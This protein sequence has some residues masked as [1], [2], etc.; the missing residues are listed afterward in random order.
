MP[1]WNERQK[2]VLDSLEKDTSILVSA[3]AGSGK[4]A[5]LVQRII[6]TVK[7]KKAGIDEILVVTFTKAAASQMK[8]KIIKSLEAEAEKGENEEL[9]RQLVL[10]E[11]A[12]IM[13]ID[14]FCNKVVRNNFSIARMDPSF[15]IQD[16]D[17]ASILKEEVLDKVLDNHYKNDKVFQDIAGYIMEKNIK[18]DNL[19]KIILN[20]FNV[21]ESYAESDKWLE[22]AREK[23]AQDTEILEH[24]WVIDYIEYVKSMARGYKAVFERRAARFSL[25]QSE[26]KSA[27]KLF[28]MYM[29]DILVFDGIIAA[30]TLENM[31]NS[32]PA[33]WSSF[34]QKQAGED[35]SD[36]AKGLYKERED[37]KASIKTIF[38]EEEI[39]DD[40]KKCSDFVNCLINIVID[41]KTALMEEKR[42]LKRYEFAD[43]AHAAF[44]ILYDTEKAEPTAVGKH[45][46]MVY[47]YIYIDEYQDS[48]D[49]Q[50]N[51]LRAVSTKDSDGNPKNIFMV[52]D[53]KQSIYRFR[54]ARPELFNEKVRLFGQKTGGELI[55]LN[56]NYRSRKAVLDATNSVF[57]TIMK[58][59]F[60][61]IE[62]DEEAE[63]NTPEEAVYN[64]LYPPA[65]EEINIGGKPELIMI[66][67]ES[68]SEESRD[69]SDQADNTEEYAK[70]EIEAIVIGKKIL[71]IVNG[72]TE[73]GIAPAFVK[74]EKYNP[75]LPEDVNN[76][77]YRKAS[78]K[79][80]MILQ[81]VIKGSTPM[82][83]IYEQ[84]GIPVSLDDPHGYFDAIE[85]ETMLS[86]LRIIDNI[87]QDIPFV[88]LLL[89]HIGNMTEPEL[90]A[91]IAF[92]GMMK[93]SIVDK[94]RMFERIFFEENDAEDA[95]QAEK[96]DVPKSEKKYD[97]ETL[98]KIPGTETVAV[99]LRRVFSLIDEWTEVRPFL[100]IS[101]LIDK[102]INDT[103]Y[104][105]Y[106]AA[107]PNGKRRV[108]NIKMLKKKAE[109]FEADRNVGLF[110]FI[111]YMDKCKVHEIDFGE[112]ADFSETGDTVHVM[113]MHKS[114]GLEFPIVILA[115]LGGEF[116]LKETTG[117]VTV[118]S[119]YHIAMD[120]LKTLS[121][122]IKLRRNSVKKI[123][124]KSL[125]EKE[126]KTEQARLLYVAMTRA[127]EK[128]F[129]VGT[130]SKK[131]PLLP[132][133]SKSM[134][135]YLRIAIEN[136]DTSD[137]IECSETTPSAVAGMFEKVYAKKNLD[138]TKDVKRLFE[139]IGKT[140]EKMKLNATEESPDNP[141][142]YRYPMEA[143]TRQ[144]SKMSVSEVKELAHDIRRKKE[145]DEVK[146]DNS[147]AISDDI[148]K[149]ETGSGK[150]FEKS[151]RFKANMARAAKRGTATHSFFEHIDYKRI[152]SKDDMKRECE[153]ILETDL[154][155]EEEKELIDINIFIDYYSDDENSL[156]G[157]MKK[158]ELS[159]KL[160]REQQFF[161]G[162]TP[163]E[164]SGR[165]NKSSREEEDLVV[166]QGI[167]D[168]FFYEGE[169]D[170][171]VLVDYK[172]DNI[173]TGDE[174]LERHK[175]QLYLYALTLEK[176][177]GKKVEDVILY[178]TKIG[179]VPYKEWRTY[180]DEK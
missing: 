115:K 24:K 2:K 15:E 36:E 57:R 32:L 14:S 141:Y 156:F 118:N 143:S 20:I 72:D 8:T 89:S 127:K 104:E 162:L 35:Y 172:T 178:S 106:V 114:K 170:H 64:L 101:R 74:N 55:N 58:K 51:L 153:R 40:A 85:V 65:D 6:D 41:F 88:S 123:I 129:M 144:K 59:E 53:V 7:S 113:S 138:Y 150:N 9:M 117:F 131:T 62:Y 180:S 99:K 147:K 22:E 27:E 87:Q 91:V 92:T 151:E 1:R 171:I 152:S 4:T 175:S 82:V 49:L 142:T 33:K 146:A 108:A 135:D 132:I 69:E 44:N 18:D 83:R 30:T 145:A 42:K 13:T 164:I 154:Y 25:E 46:S 165:L 116:K 124:M 16:S 90:A 167:I 105:S 77:K 179:E 52:G 111:R 54:L 75:E 137:Y 38:S 102:V 159:G 26:K 10:A 95:V 34:P 56:M 67:A 43:V 174:L 155:T 78:F 71:E 126:I 168:A 177:T 60:G 23:T 17:E 80:I 173:K 133:N 139:D 45:L 161:I 120:L 149:K 157:R 158:A 76:Q 47:K 3:A 136:G 98:L 84:M 160:S 86:V 97:K 5:V 79:D 112:A 19:R 70:N 39:I 93:I 96:G 163:D 110:D 103:D 169:D 28:S 140:V 37:V 134:L 128:L 31:K 94:C 109:A 119:D 122:E 148:D 12:D 130:Y 61:G 48:S 63:L 73:K 166:I 121:S 68:D 11:N 125:S 100:S 50:E 21:S 29:D 81:S 66:N 176:L 107:M